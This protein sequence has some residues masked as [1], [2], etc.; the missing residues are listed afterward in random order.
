MFLKMTRWYRYDL[1]RRY[2]VSFHVGKVTGIASDG[3]HYKNGTMVVA[4]LLRSVVSE[5]HE[6]LLELTRLCANTRASFA[7]HNSGAILWYA[8]CHQPLGATLQQP[9]PWFIISKAA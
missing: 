8:H 3:R 1:D 6:K 7:L 4:I 5:R 2:T 9:L